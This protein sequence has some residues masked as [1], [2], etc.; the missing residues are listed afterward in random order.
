MT[1]LTHLS[2]DTVSQISR[3]VRSCTGVSLADA[4]IS[5]RM[6]V[7]A[8]A[9]ALRTMDVP[10]DAR[11]EAVSQFASQMSFDGAGSGLVAAFW[12]QAVPESEKTHTC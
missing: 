2:A 9:D 7:I 10:V 8:L 6:S 11:Y 12:E 5:G 1:M 3:A 4:G